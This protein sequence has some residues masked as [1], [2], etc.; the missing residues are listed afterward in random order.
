MDLH[1]CQDQGPLHKGAVAAA[2]L[3]HPGITF[4][5]TCRGNDAYGGR[6]ASIDLKKR[7]RI[8]TALALRVLQ[9]I[10]LFIVFAVPWMIIVPPWALTP[11]VS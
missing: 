3:A 5:S 10:Q 2:V 11:S 8:E 6:D 7:I 1:A 4:T 9:L